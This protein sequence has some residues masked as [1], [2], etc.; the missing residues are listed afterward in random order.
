MSAVVLPKLFRVYISASG[1]VKPVAADYQSQFD[2][3]S[4]GRSANSTVPMWCVLRKNLGTSGRMQNI[5]IGPFSRNNQVEVWEVDSAGTRLTPVFWGAFARSHISIGPG[6]ESQMIECQVHP[7]WHF[8]S[9]CYGQRQWSRQNDSTFHTHQDI[10]FNPEIDGIIRNNMLTSVD[11]VPFLDPIW[12]DAESTMSTKA[13]EWTAGAGETAQEWTIEDIVNAMCDVCNG[14]ETYIKNPSTANMAAVF[15]GTDIPPVRNLVLRRGG[16]LPE[17]LDAILSPYGIGWYLSITGTADVSET[18]I[19]LYKRGSGTE[20]TVK[21]QIT[22]TLDTATSNVE[23]IDISVDY[24]QARNRCVVHGA[25]YEREVTMELFRGWP[26]AEDGAEDHADATVRSGRLF[27]ANEAGDVDGMRA[28]NAVPVIDGSRF[29]PRRR[30]CEDMLAWRDAAA[31]PPIL[32]DRQPPR[33]E[34]SDDDGGTWQPVDQDTWDCLPN[35]FGIFVSATDQ[36]E[37]AIPEIFL[38]S[39]NRYRLTGM[40]RGEVRVIG[41]QA[42]VGG[43]PVDQEAHLFIDASDRYFH[44]QRQTFG[45]AASQATGTGDTRDDATAI[46]DYAVSIVE[47]TR[48]ATVNARAELFA[49]DYATYQLGDLIT[50]LE[51]REISF[52][53]NTIGDPKYPQIVRLEC[54]VNPQQR[55]L[56]MLEPFNT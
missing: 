21:M 18:R 1:T 23:S 8:G 20:K 53:C 44:R 4:F 7:H 6:G 37:A 39:A 55:T 10:E 46:Q 5:S 38:N 36:Q 13:I 26:A 42:N 35:Q 9:P 19:V 14:A 2:V 28:G 48:M 3:L 16:V 30:V 51:G 33:L 34:V 12:I 24:T 32:L 27:V 25:F 22:G 17:Y 56:L 52:N 29:Q 41:D 40:V 31:S 43:S 15:A 45:V 47:K 11:G 50:K 54:T 49:I